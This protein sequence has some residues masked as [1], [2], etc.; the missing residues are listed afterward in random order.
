MATFVY[1]LEG[2]WAEGPPKVMN[3]AKIKYS[4]PNWLS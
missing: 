4:D 3:E 2:K 1:I